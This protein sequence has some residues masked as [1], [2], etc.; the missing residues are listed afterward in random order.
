MSTSPSKSR[1][2]TEVV[3][4]TIPELVTWAS[5]HDG[6]KVIRF[7]GV[8]VVSTVVSEL[9]ISGSYGLNWTHSPLVATLFGNVVAIFPAYV[10]HRQWVWGKRGASHWRNEVLPYFVISLLG[11]GF[12][13]LGA[14]YCRSLVQSH[15]LSHA[16]NTELVAGFNLV[17]FAMF[18]VLKM[19]LFNKIFHTSPLEA[20][21]EHLTAEEQVG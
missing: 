19:V 2:V 16:I 12:S 6:K 17:S 15:H 18:W 4:R 11:V 20:F 10:L 7:A 8:S 1:A 9:A 14:L 13:M 3:P 21:D 5:S